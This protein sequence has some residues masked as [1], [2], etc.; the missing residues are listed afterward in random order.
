[1]TSA[2][3]ISLA[4]PLLM[5]AATSYEL[6]PLSYSLLFPSGNVIL[7]LSAKYSKKLIHV[8]VIRSYSVYLSFQLSLIGFV[9]HVFFVQVLVKS[10]SFLG[11]VGFKVIYCN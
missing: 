11:E 10:C 1:F 3:R 6:T 7:I 5:E 8:I 2:V 4:S 9:R